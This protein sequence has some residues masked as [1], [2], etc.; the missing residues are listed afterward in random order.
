MRS[1]MQNL[2]PRILCVLILFAAVSWLQ[3]ARAAE[4]KEHA[5]ASRHPPE[6]ESHPAQPEDTEWAHTVIVV[7]LTL[8]I[9]AIPVGIIVRAN[10]PEE[11]P[12]THSHDE[13]PG[14]SGHHGPSGAVD[15]QVDGHSDAGHH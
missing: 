2:I 9:A 7:I 1:N 15:D 13:P 6:I 12:I 3:T 4:P 10:M 5:A 11:I 14:A 8:F